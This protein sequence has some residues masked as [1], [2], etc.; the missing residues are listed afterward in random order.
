M[1][2]ASG[3]SARRTL[4]KKLVPHF[5]V[6]KSRFRERLDAALSPAT[7]AKR[8]AAQKAEAAARKGEDAILIG[9]DTLAVAGRAVYGKPRNLAHARAILRALS[10]KKHR[11]VTGFALL[12]ARSGARISRSVSTEVW[13]RTLSEREIERYAASGEPL[14]A[15]GGYRLQK[16]GARLVRRVRGGRD[17]VAGL[18]L[19]ALRG[20]LRR[21]KAL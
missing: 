15:A 20:A 11:I 16:G 14:G 4:L 19:A 7:L 2:L 21:M 10:G 13:F 18:P 12:D 3:S 8:L 6:R 17:N 1:V 5:E 9:A